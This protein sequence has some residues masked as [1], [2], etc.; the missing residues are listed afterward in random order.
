MKGKDLALYQA[1]AH[2][3]GLQHSKYR[4]IGQIGQGQFGRVFCGNLRTTGQLVALKEL[5]HVSAPTPQFLRELWSI[6]SLRHP[7][8]VTGQALEHTKTGRY[9]VMDYCEGGTLR[10]LMEQGSGLTLAEG[11][12]IITGILAGLEHSHQQG[13]LHCDIKP[14][15]ILL[16]LK[17][18]GWMPRLTDFGIARRFPAVASAAGTT[19]ESSS[20]SCMGTPAY[21]APERFY[22]LS[23]P[24]SDL[25]AVGIIL[26]ELLL[27][28]R[29]F[30]GT[31]RHLVWAHMNQR[32]EPS[33]T[34][35]DALQ[36]IVQKSLEKLPAR[37]FTSAGA[38]IQAI[39]QVVADPQ[40]KPLLE[41]RLPL[42]NATQ[43]TSIKS[44]PG[45]VYREA[46]Q[47]PLHALIA[48]GNY[49]YGISKTVLTIWPFSEPVQQ[50]NTQ[51]QTLKTTLPHSP[52]GQ[53]LHV[54]IPDSI[55]HLYSAPNGCYLHAGH[56][57]YWLESKRW[58]LHLLVDTPIFLSAIDPQHQWLAVVSDHQ[59][60]QLYSLQA[61]QASQNPRALLKRTL[62][63]P[64]KALTHLMFLDRRHL[65]V[66]SQDREK[67]QTCFQIYTRRGTVVGSI[68]LP[69]MF[70]D[71]CL[72]THPYTLFGLAQ[73]PKPTAF[74][75]ELYPLKVL[76]IPLESLPACWTTTPEAYALAARTG[77]IIF[78]DRRGQRVN[79]F[80]SDKN[81]TAMSSWGT[82][83][84]AIAIQQQS[85][86]ELY[87]LQMIKPVESEGE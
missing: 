64:P 51:A 68:S 44:L 7:H 10:N 79:L 55:Q 50:Q 59:L 77:N 58:Q 8:I 39:K 5:S 82:Q 75:I 71:V 41:R 34:L 13:V 67:N 78:F 63:L 36:A 25:Y 56:Q 81:P 19:R 28:Q 43:P 21:M 66:I 11:L 14:E 16:T 48:G 45:S 83:G 22:G 4:I 70:S 52:L 26:Y 3:N 15:N 85:R 9:L 35:P 42:E 33:S 37:R 6:I 1:P 30:S 40:V 24:S 76:R 60:L 84:L 47:T 65:L 61:G 32:L 87:L 18:A 49:L 69:I 29:P 72:T 54:T 86:C 46:L 73:K 2:P 12:R 80:Q 23:F 31:P 62:P 38:M 17:S 74:Q 57:L 27:N 20:S 53:P